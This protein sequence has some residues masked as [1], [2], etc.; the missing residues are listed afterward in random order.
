MLQLMKYRLLSFL[1]DKSTMFWSFFFPLV[2]CTLFYVTFGD[3]DTSLDSINTAVVVKSETE[4]AKAFQSFLQMIEEDED[5][6]VSVEE[7][8]EKKAKALLKDGKIS[9]I[10][11]VNSDLELLVSGSGTQESV[12]QVLLEMFQSNLEIIQT[13][14]KEKPEKLPA[15][16]ERISSSAMETQ[17][18]K[19]ASLGG[20]ETDGMIQYFYSL[21]A[22][23]CMFGCFLGFDASMMIQANIYPVGARRCVGA[24]S[25]MKLILA[26]FALIC[27]INFADVLVLLG[28][29]AGILKLDIGENIGKILLVSFM[30]CVIGVSMGMLV[31]SVGKWK[32]GTKIAIMLSVSLGSSFLSGLM[33][34]GVKGLVE[35]YCPVINRI[36]PASLISDAFYYMTIYEDAARYTKDV[37]TMAVWAVVFLAG[38]FMMVR[39]VRYDSI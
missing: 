21:I 39:R 13:V 24:T 25:K 6:M 14:A 16:M 4:E 27:I 32:E 5:S 31:G 15:L 19:E 29:M 2:L 8:S 33:A 34:S 12:L 11:Y 38:S 3:L 10:Y 17:Y 36:N 9:G 20:K 7:M 18:V 35:E 22:M 1:R 30:G 37:L 23:T 26:D 28:Y